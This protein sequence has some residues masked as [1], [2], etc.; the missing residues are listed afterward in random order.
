MSIMK[1][2]MTEEFFELNI[3]MERTPTILIPT[4]VCQTSRTFTDNICYKMKKTRNDYS[5]GVI[6]SDISDHFPCLFS[7][8]NENIKE[9]KP[10]L[11]CSRKLTDENIFKVNN[12]LLHQ[13]W[14][15]LESMEINEA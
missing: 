13:D 8:Q 9:S 12:D 5:A 3:T 1:H 11:F 4:R 14:S 2:K 15:T 7:L 6:L 10:K